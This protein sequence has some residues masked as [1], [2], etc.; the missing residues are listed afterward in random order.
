MVTSDVDD[1]V[2]SAIAI[3]MRFPLLRL[4]GMRTA[5]FLATAIA[6]GV[7]LMA[8]GC[9]SSSSATPPPTP[10]HSPTAASTPTLAPDHGIVEITAIGV[11]SFDLATIP[12]A[13]LHNTA[14]R[15]GAAM[16]VVHFVTQRSD[17]RVLGSLDSVPVN[18]GP[19]QTLAVTADCTDAC[20]DASGTAAAVTVGAW[21]ST[22]GVSLAAGPTAYRCGN[23]GS[24]HGHGDTTGS[25]TAPHLSDGAAVVVF[26][27]C[28]GGDGS[29]VGGGSEEIVWPGGPA[30]NVDVPVL[31]NSPPAACQLGASTGW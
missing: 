8:A 26:A 11:G 23:C 10:T 5:G 24:G 27:S 30:L 3:P 21:V 28:V 15:H 19:G 31:V 18:L 17:G 14:S 9:G 7:A 1:D 25:I 4:R 2:N 22:P 13:I 20:V 29:I 6:A 16:V 12:V